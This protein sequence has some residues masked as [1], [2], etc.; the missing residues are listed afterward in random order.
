MMCNNTFI[1]LIMNL[2]CN[3]AKYKTNNAKYKNQAITRL[4][5]PM[6]IFSKNVYV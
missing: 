6:C 3:N 1:N 2:S 4:T 5:L